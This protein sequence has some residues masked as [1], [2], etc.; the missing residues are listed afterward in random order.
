MGDPS[1]I[2]STPI[3]KPG[4]ALDARNPSAEKVEA[5]GSCSSLLSQSSQPDQLQVL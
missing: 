4:M 2:P 3:E 5:G 1:S